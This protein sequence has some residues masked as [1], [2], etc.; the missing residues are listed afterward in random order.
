VEGHQRDPQV[1]RALEK[2]HHDAAYFKVLGS[3]PSA[4]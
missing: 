3:Y 2:L 1:A 4:R